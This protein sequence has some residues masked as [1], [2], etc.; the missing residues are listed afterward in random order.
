MRSF[1]EYL[2]EAIIQNLSD[3][4]KGLLTAV[5]VS[6]TPDQAYEMAIGAENSSAA[7]GQLSQLGYVVV[8]GKS[9]GLT[10][11]GRQALFQNNILDNTGKLTQ[12]GQT[13][14]D[15]FQKNKKE[16]IAAT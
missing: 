13:Q 4:Q 14:L 6:A 10:P 16:F 5:V 9:V 7:L 8:N 11:K 12:E 2:K 15:N 3:F 1:K